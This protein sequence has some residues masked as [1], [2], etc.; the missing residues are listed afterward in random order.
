MILCI[1]DT[2][3]VVCKESLLPKDSA[4]VMESMTKS[5]KEIIEITRE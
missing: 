4:R 1:G 3:I 2:F 5:G